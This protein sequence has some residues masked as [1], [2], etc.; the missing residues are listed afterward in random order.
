MD[1]EIN[2][3]TKYDLLSLKNFE[4]ISGEGGQSPLKSKVDWFVIPRFSF[5]LVFN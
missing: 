1:G 2:T 5:T 4:K 3:P